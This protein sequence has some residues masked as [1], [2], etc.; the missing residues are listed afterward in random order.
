M[1]HRQRLLV[2]GLLAAGAALVGLLA[3]LPRFSGPKTLSGYVEGEPLYIAAPVAGTVRLVHVRKGQAVASGQPLFVVDP[4]IVHGRWRSPNRLWHLARCLERLD[5]GLRARGASLVVVVGRPAEVVP[6]V[7]ATIGATL[8]V[9]SRDLTPY[10]RARD[11]AV[12]EVAYRRDDLEGVLVLLDARGSDA[13]LRAALR[14]VDREGLLLRHALPADGRWDDDERLR[15]A[16]LKSPGAWWA[17][18][19]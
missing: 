8:V 7:A 11:D 12:R 16:A 13:A 5:E 9:A 14:A 10:G 3:G 15:R 17:L 1:N 19:G 18:A 4:A 2:L 6:R